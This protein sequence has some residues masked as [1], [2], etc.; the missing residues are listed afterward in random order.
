MKKKNSKLNLLSS[1]ELLN[2]KLDKNY[3]LIF[4]GN[5]NTFRKGHI[6]GSIHISPSEIICGSPPTPGKLPSDDK[7]LKL[8]NRLELDR[9]KKIIVYDDEG[10]GWAGRLIWTLEVLSYENLFFLDG[11]L[12]AW[13]AEK[14]PIENGETITE[15]F[16]LINPIH[17]NQEKLISTE[18]L[19]ELVN[20]DSIQI[21]DARSNE[22][23]EGKKY[24]AKR[25]GHIPG[26]INLDWNMLK[27]FDNHLKLKP[28]NE[29]SSMLELAGF[30]KEKKI[31]THCQ[32]HHR[33]GL[34]YIVGR[35]LEY[36]IFA[37]DG[38]WSE[39]GNRNDTPIEH[40]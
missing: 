8:V 30:N 7:L 37:Y 3:S 22:E 38:S 33:S 19:I 5:E 26:A 15:D 25:N 29:I 12:N 23:Y 27:D 28:L 34:T 13:Y 36:D 9:K 18:T 1:N 11:G 20:D 4:V 32:S 2:I 21:W 39:W 16:A 6:P 17:L 31:I 40:S 14:K 35:L 10:G 24:T